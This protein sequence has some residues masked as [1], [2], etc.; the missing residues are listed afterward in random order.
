MSVV[1]RRLIIRNTIDG[2]EELIKIQEDY[3]TDAVVF[4]HFNPKDRTFMFE[5]RMEEGDSLYGKTVVPRGKIANLG[6]LDF[7]L[8]AVTNE[9]FEEYGIVAKEA[10][11]LGEERVKGVRLFCFL[12]VGVLF[13]EFSNKEPDKH[14]VVRLTEAEVYQQ[15]DKGISINPVFELESTQRV[16]KRAHEE[17][18]RLKI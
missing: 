2:D 1:E 4:L 18:E 17:M 10:V 11:Y 7:P 3:S 14:E 16:L 5:R 8:W 15:T 12:T 6:E 13:G 9:Q